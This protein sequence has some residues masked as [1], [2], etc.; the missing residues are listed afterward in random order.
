ME[1]YAMERSN[2]KIAIVPVDLNTGANA[3]AR[4]S[5]ADCDRVT[6]YIQTGASTAAVLNATF[7]QH[8]AAS[9]GSSKALSIAN[10]YYH[11][12]SSA[13]V[14]TKLVPAAAESSHDFSTLFAT[15]GGI[16]VVEVLAEDLDVSGGFG[17][18]SLSIDDTT[19]AKVGSVI[20]VTSKNRS[21]PAYTG[22]L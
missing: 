16:I 7:N 1:S 3:G 20:A 4:I 21:K 2:A 14:F 5:M 13:T 15:L 10:P 22:T 19:A 12:V 18:V 6:F 8:D 17:Y 9:S 11:K